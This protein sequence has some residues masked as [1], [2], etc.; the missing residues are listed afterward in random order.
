MATHHEAVTKALTDAGLDTTD[1]ALAKMLTEELS[2]ARAEHFRSLV[3]AGTANSAEGDKVLKAVVAAVVGYCAHA[4]TAGPLSPYAAK[5]EA[6]L[7][8]L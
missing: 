8:S 1:P 5:V 3:A 6:A 4:A 7:K 2:S